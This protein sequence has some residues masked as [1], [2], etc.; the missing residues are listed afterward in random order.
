MPRVSGQDQLPWLLPTNA[1]PLWGC[2]DLVKEQQKPRAGGYPG[3]GKAIGVYGSFSWVPFLRQSPS[4]RG[5]TWLGRMEGASG[6]LLLE[7]NDDRDAD[8][9]QHLG[10]QEESCEEWSSR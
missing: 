4:E 5:L 8:Q 6:L 1:E 10:A 3:S 2:Q 9:Q 7:D